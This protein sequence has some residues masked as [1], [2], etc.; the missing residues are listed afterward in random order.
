MF[1]GICLRKYLC[2]M[3]IG[4]STASTSRRFSVASAK[5][6]L[7][8]VGLF[9]SHHCH[10]WGGS[11]TPSCV[12]GFWKACPHKKDMVMGVGNLKWLKSL[13][14]WQREGKLIEFLFTGNVQ[15]LSAWRPEVPYENSSTDSLGL[16]TDVPV[17]WCSEVC[18]Y[19]VH[20][21]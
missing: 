13:I 11:R 20:F 15:G 14:K 6:H 4:F 19:R 12:L 9:P 3:S 21:S 5:S 10:F 17:E 1:H 2:Q 8:V 18:P 7:L 16:E